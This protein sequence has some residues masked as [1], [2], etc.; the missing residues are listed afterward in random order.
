MAYME[1]SG[2]ILGHTQGSNMRAGSS[3]RLNV[4]IVGGSIAGLTL[5]HCFRHNN[6]DFVLLEAGADLAPQ[7]GAALVVCPN[8]GRILDQLGIFDD[9]LAIVEPLQKGFTWT[10]DGELVIDSNAPVLSGVR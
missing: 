5:A 10:H 6:I 3:E 9:I 7:V 2:D 4:I 8:G 1:S